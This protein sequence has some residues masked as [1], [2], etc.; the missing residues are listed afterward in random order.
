[1]LQSAM[2]VRKNGLFLFQRSMSSFKMVNIE[3]TD[4]GY[5]ILELNRKPVNSLSLEFLQ[6]ING[7][8]KSLEDD[9]SCRGAIISS[10]LPVF[11]AGLDLFEMHEPKLER[12]ETFWR[13]FQN[14]K[15]NLFKSPLVLMAAINGACPAGGCAIAFSCDYRIIAEGKHTMGLNETQIGLAA[16][17][18]LCESMKLLTGHCEAERLLS[19]SVLMKPQ[20]ALSKGIVDEVVA[21]EELMDRTKE[22]MEKWLQIPD[23]GRIQTKK[24]LRKYFIEEFEERREEDLRSFM[25][26][27]TNPKLQQLLGFYIQQLKQK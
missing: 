12:L 5:S 17:Y 20:E 3:P 16:P 22:Q 1:M 21:P 8:L 27:V 14:M 7:A 24:Q 13:E 26:G 11:S 10:K 15:L 19:L 23:I 6:E 25:N 9:K 18:W 2:R 4:K